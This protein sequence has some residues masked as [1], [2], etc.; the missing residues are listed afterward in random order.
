MWTVKWPALSP[1]LNFI[2]HLWFARNRQVYQ[3]H[4]EINM[5]RS[6]VDLEVVLG[7]I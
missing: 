7:A 6:E 2:K 5:G 1:D 3:L 4:L